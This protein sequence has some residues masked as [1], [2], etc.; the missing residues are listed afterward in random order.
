MRRR[1]WNRANS[2]GKSHP[3]RTVGEASSFIQSSPTPFPTLTYKYLSFINFR[4]LIAVAIHTIS[5]RKKGK[6]SIPILRSP[7]YNF[8]PRKGSFF[9]GFLGK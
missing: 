7:G 5:N 8:R 2:L 1:R 6:K 3:A 4:E 9:A